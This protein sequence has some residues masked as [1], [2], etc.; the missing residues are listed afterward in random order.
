MD[1]LLNNKR[2]N[3]A[4]AAML[5]MIVISAIVTALR[6]LAPAISKKIYF[7][8]IYIVWG[9]VDIAYNDYINNP[10]LIPIMRMILPSII[11]II[12]YFAFWFLSWRKMSF[13]VIN[14]LIY[15]FSTAIFVLD[16]FRYRSLTYLVV[17]L[18]YAG[19]YVFVLLM[20]LYH[21]IIGQGIEVSIEEEDEEVIPDLKYKKI[22]YSSELAGIN[23]QIKIIWQKKW[24]GNHIFMQFYLDDNHFGYLKNNDELIINTDANEHIITIVGHYDKVRPLQ[25]VISAGNKNETYNVGI[26]SRKLILKEICV[27]NGEVTDNS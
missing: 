27:Y 22:K 9:Y 10:T 12:V 20:G 2:Y 23:R 15:L 19:A 7:M 26:A 6:V 21:G 11:I 5:I 25:I 17:G 1:N 13:M 24:Y 14:L 8:S 3:F 4:R 18:I 16:T